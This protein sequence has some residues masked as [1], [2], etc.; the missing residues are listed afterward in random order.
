MTTTETQ[1]FT[2]DKVSSTYK[3]E[4]CLQHFCFNHLTEHRQ[5]LGKQFDEIEKNRDQ[6]QQILIEQKQNPNKDFLIQQIHQW[7]NDS[8]K[9]IRQTGNKCKQ[10]LIEHTN[11]IEN[12]LINL[13]QQLRENRQENKFNEINLNLFKIQL[14]NLTKELAQPPN[15]SI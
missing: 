2:C 3:C 8:I 14:E 1:C 15:V 5:I 11:E 13:T 9:K 4:G 10:I 12:K 7:E 6:F